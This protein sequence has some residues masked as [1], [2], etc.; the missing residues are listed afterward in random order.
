MT[1]LFRLL[2]RE[3]FLPLQNRDSKF[4]NGRRQLLVKK[5]K[6]VFTLEAARVP[7]IWFVA[8]WCKRGGPIAGGRLIAISHRSQV[9]KVIY[10]AGCLHMPIRWHIKAFYSIP[11]R[12]LNCFSESAAPTAVPICRT[13]AGF[14]GSNGPKDSGLHSS[15]AAIPVIAPDWLRQEEEPHR[16]SRLRSTKQLYTTPLNIRHPFK[17]ITH[18]LA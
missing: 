5:K 8:K 16:R 13:G 3:E 1:A 12:S 15:L 6:N 2:G 17:N 9:C 11:E 4:S 18:S 10:L 14:Y 7:N